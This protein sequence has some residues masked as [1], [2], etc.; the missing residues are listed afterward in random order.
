MKKISQEQTNLINAA[1]AQG[2]SQFSPAALEK[3]LHLTN[4]LKT[5]YNF[6]NADQ[7]LVFAGG[8]SLSKGYGLISRMSEDLD[9]K[10]DLS[11]DSRSNLRNQLGMLR[12]TIVK[13]LEDQDFKI[14]NKYSDNENH[15]SVIEIQY[16]NGFDPDASLRTAIKIELTLAPIF[17][18]SEL[19]SIKTLLYRD[20]QIEESPLKFAC[21]PP[22]QTLAEKT[23]AVLLRYLPTLENSPKTRD[24]RLVR[25]IYD[26]YQLHQIQP[27]KD[28]F[29]KI[30]RLALNEDLAKKSSQKLRSQSELKTLLQSF[31]SQLDKKALIKDDYLFFVKNLVAGESPDFETA[32]AVFQSLSELAIKDI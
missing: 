27:N 6:S 25:H 17:I 28:L 31:L 5:I 13:V 12:N 32:L 7:K 18:P 15:H 21:V 4:V 30:F 22:I 1:T 26:I 29:V 3:D 23:I 8:T 2:L 16:E 11:F 24:Q 20:L 19:K 10:V 9:F 14:L